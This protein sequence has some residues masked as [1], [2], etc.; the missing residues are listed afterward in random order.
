LV[1]NV[2]DQTDRPYRAFY[3]EFGVVS[4]S[5]LNFIPFGFAGG[6]YDP[7]TGL[8]RFGARDYDPNIGRWLSKD[9][10]L[11]RGG[12]NL[13]AYSYNDPINYIDVDGK[14]PVIIAVAAFLS[15]LLADN[16]HEANKAAAAQVAAPFLGAAV[17]KIVGSLIRGAGGVVVVAAVAGRASCGGA[18]EGAAQAVIRKLPGNLF[19]PLQ[20][21][22]CASAIANALKAEGISGEVLNITAKAGP[23]GQAVDFIVSDLVGGGT[24]LTQN[25][26]HQA[27]RV[28]DVVFDNFSREG[29]PYAEYVGALGARFGVVIESAPF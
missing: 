10:S 23:Q 17:G 7:D 14:H 3:D 6:L 1:I 8:L 12:V 13:Y 26:F 22:Q 25:G 27:V 15:V 11:F 2:T 4:G 24:S 20:C 29:V 28:G 19:K 16:Q 18:A 9:P 21:T 5:G